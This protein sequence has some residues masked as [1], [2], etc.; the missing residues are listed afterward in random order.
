MLHSSPPYVPSVK[1]VSVCAELILSDTANV[2]CSVPMLCHCMLCESVHVPPFPRVMIH[3]QDPL[4][5]RTED[6]GKQSGL[7][8]VGKLPTRFSISL[9]RFSSLLLPFTSRFSSRLLKMLFLFH[10]SWVLQLPLCLLLLLILF[11]LQIFLSQSL[12][13]YFL[14]STSLFLHLPSSSLMQGLDAPQRKGASSDNSLPWR[15]LVANL[16]CSS[17][18]NY[19]LRAP[20]ITLQLAGLENCISTSGSCD[21]WRPA[22]SD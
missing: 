17:M 1:L 9:H 16:E 4:D 10:L 7:I 15:L 18:S 21:D 2:G 5:G 14:S 11:F 19:D 12:P 8:L 3:L 6:A 20:P 13:I 22:C